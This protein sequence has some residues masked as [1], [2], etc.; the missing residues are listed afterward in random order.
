MEQAFQDLAS[1][2][3]ALLQVSGGQVGG[4]GKRKAGTW[5]YP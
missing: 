5:I 2:D 1:R 3:G 4:G